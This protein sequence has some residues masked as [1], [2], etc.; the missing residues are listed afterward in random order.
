MELFSGFGLMA[1][2]PIGGFLYAVCFHIFCLFSYSHAVYFAFHPRPVD[3][4]LNSS[5]YHK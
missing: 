1:G 5:S 4:F 3:I 2:P